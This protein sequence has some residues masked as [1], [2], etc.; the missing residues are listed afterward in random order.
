M[1]TIYH[2][3]LMKLPNYGKIFSQAVLTASFWKKRVVLHEQ[4]LY[5]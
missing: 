1:M 4:M 3:C 2:Q 5:L